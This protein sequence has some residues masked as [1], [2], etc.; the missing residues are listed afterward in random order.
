MIVL[1]LVVPHDPSARPFALTIFEPLVVLCHFILVFVVDFGENLL[2]HNLVVF[3]V[4]LVLAT[5]WLLRD[6]GSFVEDFRRLWVDLGEE[7]V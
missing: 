7:L 3:H 5:P 4:A 2:S 6:A 1:D